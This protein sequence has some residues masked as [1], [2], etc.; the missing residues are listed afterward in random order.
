MT[1]GYVFDCLYPGSGSS[2]THS[3]P[4][5]PVIK[6]PPG[7]PTYSDLDN[8]LHLEDEDP[9]LASTQSPSI[10][11]PPSCASD[12][13]EWSRQ[14]DELDLLKHT[15]VI[16]DDELSGS[17]CLSGD[18]LSSLSAEDRLDQLVTGKSTPQKSQSLE[19][20]EGSGSIQSQHSGSSQSQQS[21]QS[22]QGGRTSRPQR[23]DY[24]D[25]APSHSSGPMSPKLASSTASLPHQHSGSLP[26]QQSGAMYHRQLPNGAVPGTAQRRGGSLHRYRGARTTSL[27]RVTAGRTV[28]PT[29]T[30]AAPGARA[31][32]HLKEVEEQLQNIFTPTPVEI[33]KVTLH[34]EKETDSFGFS[35][36]DGVY[37]KGVYVSALQPGG[38]AERCVMLRPYDRLLQVSDNG[39]NYGRA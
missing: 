28:S 32:V 29:A 1:N 15:E 25:S 4:D 26:H 17:P 36:S 39:G 3:M 38:P 7:G 21:S 6:L 16:L 10:S 31:D 9:E 14:V 34:R 35:V 24:T 33:L 8:I 22:V 27:D 2:G 19:L 13:D 18:R 20:L 5:D 12:T 37:E 11:A 23:L 30:S